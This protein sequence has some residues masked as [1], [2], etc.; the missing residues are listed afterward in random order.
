VS[1]QT[2]AKE[3]LAGLDQMEKLHQRQAELLQAIRRRLD[4]RR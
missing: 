1:R 3:L 2:E 4:G